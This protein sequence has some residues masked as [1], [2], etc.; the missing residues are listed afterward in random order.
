MDASAVERATP[1]KALVGALERGISDD[2]VEFPERHVHA[3]TGADETTSSLLVMPA[4]DRDPAAGV[5]GV[6]LVTFVPANSGRG[7]P[8]ISA[9]YVAFDRATGRPIAMLDGDALT[10]RRTAAISALGA[11]HLARADSARLLVVG[12]GQ[13][14]PSI[15]QAHVAVGGIRSVQ[16]WGRNAERTEEA[17]ASVRPSVA[18]TIERADDLRTAAASADVIVCATASTAPLLLGA[19]IRPGTHVS[20]LGSFRSDMRETD[21]ELISRSRLYVDSRAGALSCGDI[22]KP[23]ES[24]AI[25]EDH[26]LGDIRDL[27]DGGA[28][29]ASDRRGRAD[30]VTVFKSVGFASADLLTAALALREA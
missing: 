4:W 1:W 28:S 18:A 22:V 3:M 17:V 11:R 8:S 21:D 26:V 19:W 16:I 14:V 24:G 5:V 13:L 9:V 6:K 12:S 15:V 10:T 29:P 23:I 27:V 30:A 25:G 7:A 2:A 20:L